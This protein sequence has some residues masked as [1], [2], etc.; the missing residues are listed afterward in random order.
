MGIYGDISRKD[1]T[2]FSTHQ[3]AG[4]ITF[5]LVV[6][7]RVFK[8]REM[9]AII[10]M[11]VCGR[12][13]RQGTESRDLEKLLTEA[14][15]IIMRVGPCRRSYVSPA[16]QRLLM[17]TRLFDIQ[18]IYQDKTVQGTAIMYAILIG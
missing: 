11:Y 7:L 17:E 5:S 2:H 14:K 12:P 13:I 1:S 6:Q 9:F 15:L 18:Y 8:R 16:Y 4:S 10:C 3:I